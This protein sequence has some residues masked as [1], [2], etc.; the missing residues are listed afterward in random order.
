MGA[1]MARS[2]DD[3]AFMLRERTLRGVEVP[4]MRARRRSHT[5][6]AVAAVRSAVRRAVR[7][8]V[9]SRVARGGAVV[10][11]IRVPERRGD[12][13]GEALGVRRRGPTDAPIGVR[14]LGPPWLVWIDDNAIVSIDAGVVGRALRS[15][16]EEGASRAIPFTAPKRADRSVGS[17]VTARLAR[18]R[19]TRRHGPEQRQR[20]DYE[21]GLPSHVEELVH[22][23]RQIEYG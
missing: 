23:S 5:S 17:C 8:A 20:R 4:T 16:A 18:G 19:A 21:Q 1:S 10:R 9:S 12:A 2:V 13:A 3:L 7:R 15:V 11:H 22:A 6:P 14:R